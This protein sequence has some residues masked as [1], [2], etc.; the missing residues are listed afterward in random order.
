MHTLKNS[1]ITD[2]IPYQHHYYMIH[3]SYCHLVK[4]R[5]VFHK[6]KHNLAGL[7]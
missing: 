7:T 2:V 1:F 4:M 5:N 6:L 3:V